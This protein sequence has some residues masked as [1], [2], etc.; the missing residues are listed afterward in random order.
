MSQGCHVSR[1]IA[2]QVV[3]VFSL[4]GLPYGLRFGSGIAHA[5]DDR[6]DALTLI[7]GNHA[8]V[9]ISSSERRGQ[10]EMSTLS[11]EY[12]LSLRASVPLDDDTRVTQFIGEGQLVSGY[13]AGLLVGF[14]QRGYQLAELDSRLKRLSTAI[15]ALRTPPLNM[16]L[17]GAFVKR[18]NLKNDIPTITQ[19][20]C[21]PDASAPCELAVHLPRAICQALK[22]PCDDVFD[23]A[24]AA[25]EAARATLA[26]SA[27][28]SFFSGEVIDRCFAASWWLFVHE[29][30]ANVRK[31]AVYF[32]EPGSVEATWATLVAADPRRAATLLSA[33][34][35][36][37]AQVLLD[38]R[39]EIL[40]VLEAAFR[41]GALARRDLMITGIRASG[42]LDN[43]AILFDANLSYDRFDV[44]P[45]DLAATVVSTERSHLTA[46]ASYTSYPRSSTGMALTVR[47]GVQ[48]SQSSGA[49]QAQRCAPAP[50]LPTLNCDG[51]ALLLPASTPDGETTLYLRGAMTYQL[52][53]RP[54]HDDVIPGGELRVNLDSLGGGAI[55]S[56]RPTLFAT[57]V[58]GSFA[59]RFGIAFDLLYRIGTDE[60]EL[61]R[62]SRWAVAPMFFFGTSFASLPVLD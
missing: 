7:P 29:R 21:G 5:E 18:H 50:G 23:L 28:S 52:Q 24:Q 51:E 14:D 62:H 30:E 53:H 45:G 61:D 44:H 25:T 12:F 13:A 11:K 38:N 47:A 6:S 31:I 10:L 16:D 58:H 2:A 35:N 1:R 46:G 54:R 60:G 57:A 39:E 9:V 4:V 43:Y 33:G 55:V 34:S 59:A 19:Y 37:K 27:C 17:R 22:R 15:T 36:R 26:G 3:L 48:H 8:S 49:V 41:A 56:L 32:R 40:G 42:R 20:F